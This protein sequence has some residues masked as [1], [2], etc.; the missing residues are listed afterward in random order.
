MEFLNCKILKNFKENEIFW[1]ILKEKNLF[2]EIKIV[3]IDRKKGIFEKLQVKSMKKMKFLKKWFFWK[4]YF[5]WKND[6]FEK[7]I[8]FWKI[9]TY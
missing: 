7:I 6:F 4:D 2:S 3:K 5:F 1:N 8:F 9:L